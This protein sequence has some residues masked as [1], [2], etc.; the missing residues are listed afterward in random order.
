MPHDSAPS[1][2]ANYDLAELWLSAGRA[3]GRSPHTIASYR[4]AI[5]L[6]RR[7]RSA[8]PNLETLSK[9]EARAFTRW[10]LDTYTP[11]GASNRVRSLR[12]FYSWLIAEEEITAN[13]FKGVRIDV[14]ETPR[15]IAD[16]DQIE[17]MLARAK[18]NHRDYALLVVLIDTGMRKGECASLTVD[19]VDL[20][21]RLLTIE[22][23]KTRPR[24]VPMSERVAT[25]VSR[26]LRRRGVRP[27]SLWAVED[28]YS[29]VA[30]VIMRHSKNKL[31][32]HQ[33]RRAFATN[34]LRK[35]GSESALMRLAGWSDT[36]MIRHYT[37]DLA[38][39]IA[40]V[41]YRKLIG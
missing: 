31:T 13:P 12:A 25:A 11:G 16:D 21:N 17:A 29:L 19:G 34:W 26:W 1:V 38:D 6:L 10:L 14:P 5:G 18:A 35:G 33:L 24:I 39:E 36:A 40:A 2:S 28:P 8:D 30:K 23:S 22:Q 32:A 7:W 9:L 20:N 15:R 41:E 3:V 37:R 4:S 27:G